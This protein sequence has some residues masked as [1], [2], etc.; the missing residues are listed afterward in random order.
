MRFGYHS[1]QETSEPY[2]HED[3]SVKKIIMHK[4]FD[5]QLFINDIALLELGEPVKFKKHIVPICLPP[6]GARFIGEIA[7][8]SGFGHE[9]F[10]SPFLAPSLKEVD[11]PIVDN[12]LC[13]TW[14]GEHK[15]G[16]ELRDTMLCAGVEEGGKDSCHG[17]SGGPL[18]LRKNGR[19]ELIGVVSWGIRCGQPKSPGVY[20]SVSDY[21]DWINENMAP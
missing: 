16:D 17:D 1:L 18:L 20:T 9:Q 12:K 7:T 19:A 11:I 3:F 13:R 21:V 14:L 4:S 15:V 6:K 2:P 10:S 8:V 5:N